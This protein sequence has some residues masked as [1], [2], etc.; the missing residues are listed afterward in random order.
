[1]EKYELLVGVRFALT[2]EDYQG[3]TTTL[4]EEHPELLRIALSIP[5]A[6]LLRTGTSGTVVIDRMP[7]SGPILRLTL[8]E[9]PF[10]YVANCLACSEESRFYKLKNAPGLWQWAHM[11]RC[12]VYE[13]ELVKQRD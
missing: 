7:I 6:S 4:V 9:H 8:G 3:L 12:D 10:N 13:W 2:K 11:H 5:Q 1:M